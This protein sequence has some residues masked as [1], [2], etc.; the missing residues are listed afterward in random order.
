MSSRSDFAANSLFNPGYSA[1]SYNSVKNNYYPRKFVNKS[2]RQ[3]TMNFPGSS[4][5]I[6]KENAD[7]Y[8]PFTPN[9][10]VVFPHTSYSKVPD[11]LKI[12]PTDYAD[13]ESM[14]SEP[15]TPGTFNI[16]IDINML[17]IIIIFI[18]FIVLCT[19]IIQ[20]RIQSQ[21]MQKIIKKIK[22]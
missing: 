7:N 10:E 14:E 11:T 21:I 5:Y 2:C 6:M 1:R 19:Q 18:V 13:K 8:L 15:S 3:N 20:L 9:E 22:L 12:G 4:E 16:K 17:L